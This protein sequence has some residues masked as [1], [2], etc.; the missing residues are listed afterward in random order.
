V[1]VLQMRALISCGVLPLLLCL[2]PVSADEKPSAKKPAA[3]ASVV[4]DDPLQTFRARRQI[5]VQGLAE[6]VKADLRKARRSYPKDPDAAHKLLRDTLLRVL[7]NPDISERVRDDLLRKLVTARRKL[8]KQGSDP[9][10][11][12]PT[13]TLT[14]AKPEPPKDALKVPKEVLQKRAE[15]ARRVY[16][17]NLDR[18]RSGEGLPAELFGWS[19]RWLEAVLALCDKESERVK[20]LRDHLDRTRDVERITGAAARAGQGKQADADAATYFR[21]EAE[22]RLYKEGVKPHP[23]KEPKNKREKP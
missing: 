21:L 11:V 19:E 1:E 8:G 5:E 10:L 17:Q 18:I 12:L 23:A 9:D 3:S 14:F 4:A 2:T 16:K 7:D 6:T 15:A 13:L 22:I 20:A